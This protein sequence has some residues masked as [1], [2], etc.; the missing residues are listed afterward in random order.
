MAS[1]SSSETVVL[2]EVSWVVVESLRDVVGVLY[3]P[4]VVVVG[5]TGTVV[6]ELID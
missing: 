3:S 1:A 5:G 2:D 6:V 4:S